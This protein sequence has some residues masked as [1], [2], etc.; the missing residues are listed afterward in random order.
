MQ[1][2]NEAPISNLRSEGLL[3]CL[4]IFSLHSNSLH[5]ILGVMSSGSYCPTEVPYRIAGTFKGENFCKFRGFAEVFVKFGGIV[6]FDVTVGVHQMEWLSLIR[7]IV[8][9]VTGSFPT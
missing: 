2:V 4:P 5:G 8:S 7:Y 9:P 3:T 6:S 1:Q